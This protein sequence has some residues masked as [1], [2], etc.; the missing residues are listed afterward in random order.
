MKWYSRFFDTGKVILRQ[1]SLILISVGLASIFLW[2]SGYEP[3]AI[4]SGMWKGVTKDL[5]GTI[6]WATP[7]ILAG[8]AICVTFKAEIWNLGVDGQIYIGAAAATAV[9]L[10]IPEGTGQFLSDTTI[11]LVAMIAAM[12]FA[13]IPALLKVFF[14]TNEVV[15]TL[16]LI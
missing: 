7:L 2:L 16:L 3:F 12:A 1:F 4:F 11:I 15:S 10:K 13:I 9:A 6:R 14:E 5:A 8:L